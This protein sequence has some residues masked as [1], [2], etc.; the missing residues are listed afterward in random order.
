MVTALKKRE[1]S[2]APTGGFATGVNDPLLDFFRKRRIQILGL[3][4]RN[5]LQ[6]G[7]DQ[8]DV[9]AKELWSQLMA[10]IQPDRPVRRLIQASHP[11]DSLFVCSQALNG[12]LHTDSAVDALPYA[13]RQLMLDRID[14]AWAILIHRELQALSE[15]GDVLFPSKTNRRSAAFLLPSISHQAR[16][17]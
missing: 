13:Q 14:T 4:E 11:I 16:L 2:R 8:P 7:F 3:W 15:V 6:H 1:K 12:F 5:L 17:A 9:L 10:M